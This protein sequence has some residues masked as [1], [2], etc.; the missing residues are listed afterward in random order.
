MVLLRTFILSL[1]GRLDLF[2]FD[3]NFWTLQDKMPLMSCIIANDQLV[4]LRHVMERCCWVVSLPPH[5]YCQYTE[6]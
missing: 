5:G 4:A 3:P 1:Y 2:E 6:N